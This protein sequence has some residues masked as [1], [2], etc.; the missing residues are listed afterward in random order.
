VFTVGPLN[1]AYRDGET[2]TVY[3]KFS[4]EEGG[5]LLF[6]VAS[7]FDSSCFS[8]TY[9]YATEGKFMAAFW[10]MWRYVEHTAD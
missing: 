5:K 3:V 6:Q 10:D 1:V 9:Y 4:T 2:A 8:S 7:I